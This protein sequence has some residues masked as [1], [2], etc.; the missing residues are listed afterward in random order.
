M[1]KI[2]GAVG[3]IRHRSCEGHVRVMCVSRED[4]VSVM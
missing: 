1:G 4:H 2:L 3:E